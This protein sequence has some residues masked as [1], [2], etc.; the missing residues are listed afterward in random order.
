MLSCLSRNNA[1]DQSL[2]DLAA[3][4]LPADRPL[5][6]GVRTHP[7]AWTAVLLEMELWSQPTRLV[8]LTALA[9]TG[10][11]AVIDLLSSTDQ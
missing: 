11:V 9:T 2:C 1:S 7:C 8:Q 5:H 3:V 4:G 10:A 6:S